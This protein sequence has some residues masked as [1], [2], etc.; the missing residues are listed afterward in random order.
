MNGRA[1]SRNFSVDIIVNNYNY[2]R[3]LAD[4]VDSALAQSYPDVNVIVVDDGSTDDSRTILQRYRDRVELVLKV[5]GGQASALNAG[6]ARSKGDAVIF[7]DSD[8]LLEPTAASLVAEAFSSNPNVVKVQYRMEVV[9]REGRSTGVV[10]PPPHLPLPQ[11]DMRHAELTFPFDLAWLPTSANA[12]RRDPLRRILPMPER[13]FVACADWYVVHLSALLGPVV[14]LEDIGAAYRVHG[15]NR[16]EPQTPRLDLAHTRRT[17]AYAA[18]TAAAL[19]RLGDEL[20]LQRPEGPILSVADVANRLISLK[21]APTLHP[22]TTDR[23]WRLARDGTRAAIRRSDVSCQMKILFA[24]W[25]GS[26]SL[27]PRP[28]ARELAE[29][30]V[31]VQRRQRISQLLG[32]MHRPNR[33]GTDRAARLS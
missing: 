21:L 30:F 4:A 6:F 33:A 20:G 10:K 27:A 18:A 29:R 13:E 14:S 12:F 24:G 15:S 32:R 7:L 25:F 19:E 26:M 17:I 22:L 9:D 5:N 1:R 3:F 23:V 16:H 28:L 31:F 11:G 2:G 8:D